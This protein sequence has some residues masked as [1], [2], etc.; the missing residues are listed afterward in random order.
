MSVVFVMCFCK[1]WGSGDETSHHIVVPRPFSK[2]FHL[3]SYTQWY[4]TTKLI[5]IIQYVNYCEKKIVFV[6]IVFIKIAY[7]NIIANIWNYTYWYIFSNKITFFF[8]IY[9]SLLSTMLL[10][11]YTFSLFFC[12]ILVNTNVTRNTLT[13]CSGAYFHQPHPLSV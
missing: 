13:E 11:F 1:K 10:Y 5:H 9:L 6:L 4:E 2:D 8:V 3:H 7:Y 12:N